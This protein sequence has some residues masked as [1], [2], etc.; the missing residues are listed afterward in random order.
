VGS[1]L[2]AFFTFVLY[3]ALPMLIVGY[4]MGTPA[5]RKARQADEKS[6]SEPSVSES[7]NPTPNASSES[8]GDAVSP[9]RKEP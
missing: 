8:S 5:R 7:S 9:V 6:A 1:V 3:G 2:G 4:I